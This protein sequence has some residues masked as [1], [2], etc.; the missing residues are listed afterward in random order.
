MH[1]QRSARVATSV[2]RTRAIPLFRFT[3]HPERSLSPFPLSRPPPLSPVRQVGEIFTS[4][5][6]PGRETL[7]RGRRRAMQR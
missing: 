6:R 4:T 7:G 2:A 3:R 1:M 5:A